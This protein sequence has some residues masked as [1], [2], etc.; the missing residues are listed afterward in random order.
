[1]RLLFATF[2][3]ASSLVNP[4]AAQVVGANLSGS[5]TDDNGGVLPGVTVT[6]QNKA[7]GTQQVVATS[8]EGF[9]RVVSLQPAPYIVTAELTGF[10]VQRR[11]IVLTIGD[12]ASLDFKL[13]VASL[14]E[15][16]TVSASSPLIEV[17][18]AAPSSTIIESQIQALPVLERNFLVLA[19]LL[20]GAA[21][22]SGYKFAVTKF[23]GVADQ[24][25]GFTT[26]IDG[27]DVD[28]AIWGSPDDQ[29]DPGRGAGIQGLPQQFDAQYGAA[30][31]AVMTVVTKSGTNNLSG[32]AFYFGRNQDLNARNSFA[33]APSRRIRRSAAADRSADRS[34]R[35]GRISSAPSR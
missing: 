5:I 9:Y 6:I 26:I 29:H 20:P 25:N 33:H 17:S 34:S 32:S 19:Q 13:G 12:H 18:R 31:S 24:R 14:Q 4:A 2:L 10:G 8:V 3:L 35:T 15:S 27:G 28:D 23:G 21:P 16:I 7:N 22:Y 30:L 11:E 1:M